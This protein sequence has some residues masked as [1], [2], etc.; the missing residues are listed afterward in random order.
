MVWTPLPLITWILPMIGHT[1]ICGPD[2]MIHDFSGSFSISIDNMA[3]GKPT[4]YLPL[5]LNDS[6][7]DQYEECIDMADQKFKH[8]HH[9]LCCNNCHSH[10]AYVLELMKY[11]GKQ[12][13]TQ[14]NIWWMFMTRSKYVSF[15]RFILTYIGF[16][17]FLLLISA[18][19]LIA[20]FA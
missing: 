16:F 19:I 6:N 17:I 14:V 2:G 5:E 9:S 20:N 11:K 4:K 13:W 15:G 8:M 10:C 18:I 12:S 3:F 7:S 1:G